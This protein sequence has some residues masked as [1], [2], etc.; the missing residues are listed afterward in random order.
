MAALEKNDE[1]AGKTKLFITLNDEWYYAVQ[2][3]RKR[4]EG[5]RVTDKTKLFKTGDVLVI[6]HHTKKDLPHL[7]RTIGRIRP[8]GTYRLAL[9]ELPMEEVLP[10]AG[11]VRTIDEG[12]KIY[13]Q[14]VSLTT[15][16]SD[17]VFMIEL[18]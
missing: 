7:R 2:Y 4:W 5:R 8:Y 13:E 16:V 3:R 18:L 9:G 6:G 17:G 1:K 10:S 11:V 14:Y 12:C 15:Q